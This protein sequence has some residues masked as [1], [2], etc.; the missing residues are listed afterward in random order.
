MRWRGA[1]LLVG[2]VALAVL[3]AGL[4]ETLRDPV[5]AR[6]DVALAELPIGA[7]PLRVVHLSDLHVSWPDMPPQRLARIVDQANALN[8][9][10]IVLTGDYDGGKL[11][12]VGGWSL[13]AKLK[14]LAALRAPLGTHVVLGN[15]D[16][17]YWSNVIFRHLGIRVLGNAAVDAGPITVGG[18][19]SLIQLANP[20]D[21]VRRVAARAASGKP[22]I[23][24]AHEPD[25]FR[26]LP[27][28]VDLFIAGH[29]HG[30]QLCLPFAA[31][32]ALNPFYARYRRG[33]YRERG[34]TMIVSSG[35]GTT[36]VPLRLGVPPEIVVIE[37]RPPRT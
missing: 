25:H 29:T 28:E 27:P 17:R 2:G 11:W 8:P 37:L 16:N 26:W 21:G 32:A 6:Y 24:I 19:H 1:L 18:M 5:V 20:V 35:V 3:T 12:D 9:D 13:T 23:L 4:A 14:P 7:P 22:L 31:C 30:G 10:L 33:A 34:K 15:H 36:F